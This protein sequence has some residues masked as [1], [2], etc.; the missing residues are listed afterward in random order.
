MHLQSVRTTAAILM[1]VPVTRHQ[2]KAK[3]S[4]FMC[5][6]KIDLF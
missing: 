2:Q 1:V 4:L 3:K 6:W 5:F